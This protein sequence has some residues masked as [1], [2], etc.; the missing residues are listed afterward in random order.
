MDWGRV[1]RELRNAGYAGFE[2]DSGTTAVSGLSG[3]W[4]IGEIAREG[5]LKRENQSL[6]I[7]IC[8][9]LPG[10]AA[11]DATP[12]NAPGSIRHIAERYGLHVVIV[13]VSTDTVRIALCDPS[14]PDLSS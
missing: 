5:K 6:L 13:G 2:F 14:E 9:Y 7:R 11:V 10:S 8:D 12:E 4:L 3:E 1:K